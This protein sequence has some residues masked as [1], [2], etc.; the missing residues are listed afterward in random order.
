MNAANYLG[1][2]IDNLADSVNMAECGILR[3]NFTDR[4]GD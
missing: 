2:H 4:E 1:E 3:F